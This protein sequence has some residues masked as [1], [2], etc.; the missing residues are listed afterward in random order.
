MPAR[1]T[2][3][4]I[5]LALAAAGCGGSASGE[6]TD[7]TPAVGTTSGGATASADAPPEP[8]ITGHEAQALVADG[9]VLLDVTP[10]ARADR[11]AIEGRTHIPL[12]ELEARMGELPR[13]RTI[14][15]YCLGGRGSPRA[16]ALLRANGFDVRLL[17]ARPRWDET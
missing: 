15:V 11:S 3:G 16:A 10:T 13:D 17:G 1:V 6:S 14:V 9:A 2:A 12:P 4:L 5:A 7:D 8:D